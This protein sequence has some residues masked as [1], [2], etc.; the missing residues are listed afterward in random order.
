M[1]LPTRDKIRVIC[2]DLKMRTLSGIDNPEVLSDIRSRINHLPSAETIAVMASDQIASWRKILDKLLFDIDRAD[3]RRTFN[4]SIKHRIDKGIPPFRP[5]IL[6][7]WYQA[8]KMIRTASINH[9]GYWDFEKKW[10]N[11]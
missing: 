2:H 11:I 5:P 1:A 4:H 3:R 7:N 9:L 6:A 10:K 8:S